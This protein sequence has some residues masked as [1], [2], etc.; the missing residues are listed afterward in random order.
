MLLLLEL[1]SDEHEVLSRKLSMLN[2]IL[3][4]EVETISKQQNKIR[5]E[6]FTIDQGKKLSEETIIEEDSSLLTNCSIGDDETF[7]SP[8]KE[9]MMHQEGM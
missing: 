7:V 6:G 2:K 1:S 4:S 5:T 9:E 8:Q 3:E